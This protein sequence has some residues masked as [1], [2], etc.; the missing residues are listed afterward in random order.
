MKGDAG[1]ST[2]GNPVLG[3]GAKATLALAWEA[4]AAK[5]GNVYRAADFDDMTFA[6]MLT[7]ATAVGQA[8]DAD[9]LPPVGELIL[10]AARAMRAAVGVN[11]HLGSI[12]LMAPLAHAALA[13]G[14]SHEVRQ[15]LPRV[16]GGLTIDDARTAYQAI[17]LAA[18]GGL[19]SAPQ[20]D[21]A[22]DP[23]VDL[24]EAM[25]LASD[26]DLVARQYANDYREVLQMAD[27]IEALQTAGQPLGEATVWAYVERLGETP[28]TL[29]ARK[30]GQEVADESAAR[31]AYVLAAGPPGS[32][33]R[34]EALADLD[35]WLRADGRRRNPGATADL[36]AAALFLL[37]LEDKMAWPLRF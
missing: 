14:G 25:R 34:Y 12:L 9:P 20:Q 18:P 27:R 29:I 6:D 5:P 30:C 21:V 4:T 8:F 31:A 35:F 23:T 1:R 24:A 22:D 10:T 7:A 26:R 15:A 2:L 32:E 28:D 16:L 3:M 19:A 11:T 33:E 37:L 17:R 13:E 36:V